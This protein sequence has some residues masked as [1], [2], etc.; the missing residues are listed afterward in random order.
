MARTS[1]GSGVGDG[2][3]ERIG[4]NRYGLREQ[5]DPTV[6]E[7]TIEYYKKGDVPVVKEEKDPNL[8]VVKTIKVKK[9]S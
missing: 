6:K 4:D 5:Y 2:K 3:V 8:Q 1:Y 9:P 7:Q